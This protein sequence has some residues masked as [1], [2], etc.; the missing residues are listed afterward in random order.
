MLPG[1]GAMRQALTVCRREP[2]D[3]ATRL[4]AL[5]GLAFAV[6][7]INW[8]QPWLIE[9]LLGLIGGEPGEA[10]SGKARE[11]G[12][13]DEPGGGDAFPR[14]APGWVPA[15]RPPAPPAPPPPP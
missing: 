1:S 7:M 13:T 11:P 8:H 3:A 4:D 5:A 6:A 10:E 9:R 12:E 14:G 15:P 2:P